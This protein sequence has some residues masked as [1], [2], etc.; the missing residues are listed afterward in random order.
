M[1]KTSYY[2][3]VNELDDDEDVWLFIEVVVEVGL[4]EGVETVKFLCF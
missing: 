2:E 3:I 1:S 4:V